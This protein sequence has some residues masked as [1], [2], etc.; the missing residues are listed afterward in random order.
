MADIRIVNYVLSGGK[1]TNFGE[2]SEEEK[3]KI[4]S[5]ILSEVE[6]AVKAMW[7][8]GEGSRKEP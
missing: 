3:E 5:L 7:K 4:A 8:E 2:C 1:V 6:E